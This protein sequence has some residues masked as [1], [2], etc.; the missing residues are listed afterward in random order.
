VQENICVTVIAQMSRN[1]AKALRFDELEAL[2]LAT[3][4]RLS[5]TRREA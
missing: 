1:E 2:A 4:V 3:A 5:A